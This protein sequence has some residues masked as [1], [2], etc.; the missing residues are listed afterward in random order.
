MRKTKDRLLFLIAF[1]W[2]FLMTLNSFYFY[3]LGM[4]LFS[5]ISALMSIPLIIIFRVKYEKY[6]LLIIAVLICVLLFSLTTMLPNTQHV[7]PARIPLFFLLVPVVLFSSYLLEKHRKITLNVLK[8]ILVVHL[9][10]FFTQF[11][12]FYTTGNFI[13]YIMPI[14]GEEQRSFGGNYEIDSSG[15]EL[16][17]ATGLFNEPGTYSTY[18]FLILSLVKQLE[19][20]IFKKERLTALDLFTVV[21]VLLSFSVFGFIFSAF[22]IIKFVLKSNFKTKFII[23]IS[24]IPLV[25]LAYDRYLSVRFSKDAETSG[26]GFRTR[27]IDMYIENAQNDPF[28]LLFGY[29]NFVNVNDLFNTFIVWN[30]LGFLF[31]IILSLGVIGFF[32][33][34]LITIPRI[35]TH[36][37]AITILCLSKLSI[38]TFFLWFFLSNLYLPRRKNESNILYPDR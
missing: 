14:T 36:Y 8:T 4:P 1:V 12:Y 11:V 7:F 3:D 19:S 2:I 17:R 29:S 6:M 34:A 24:S 10:F 27:A 38:T 32:L 35:K 18:I 15:T 25:F 9:V 20:E 26:V 28:N 21:S 31:S 5:V 33:F 37:L 13:D 22:F 30:D 23:I 16:I